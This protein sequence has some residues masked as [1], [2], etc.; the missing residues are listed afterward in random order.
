MNMP[1]QHQTEFDFATAQSDRGYHLWL[2]QRRL[3]ME[4]LAQKMG[5]PLGHA[6]EVWLEGGVRLRGILCLQEERLFIE[7]ARDFNLVLTVD[8]TPFAAREIE[9]CVRLD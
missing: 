7:D 1:R 9:S 2:E 6:V 4:Q 5:L 8:N 3:A